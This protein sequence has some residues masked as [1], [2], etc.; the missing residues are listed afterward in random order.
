MQ[1]GIMPIHE[2]LA[3]YGDMAL[4]DF[5]DESIRNKL[6]PLDMVLSPMLDELAVFPQLKSEP[7]PSAQGGSVTLAS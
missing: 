7:G 5:I 6:I 2:V 3:R 4:C 1:Q